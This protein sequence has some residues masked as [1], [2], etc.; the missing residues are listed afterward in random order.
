MSER[1]VLIS[2]D[3]HAGPPV[4][5]YRA[6]LDAE[7][8]ESFDRF[9]D[10]RDRWRRTRFEAAGLPPDGEAVH[11]LFGEK[12]VESYQR[13]E[14]VRRGGVDGVHDSDRRTTELEAEG[15][16][17]E[18]LFPD[19]QNGNEPPWGAAFPFPG[20]NPPLRLAGARAYNRWLADFCGQLPGRRAG[21]A[22]VQPHDI[23]V[24]VDEVRRARAVGLASI[25]LPTGD[26][27]LAS[28]HDSRYDPLWAACVE[29]DLPVTIH[30]GGAPWEGYGPTP[31]GSRRSSS[32]GGA[33]VRSGSSSSVGCSNGSRP[34]DSR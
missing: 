8:V 28:Y 33:A 32:R 12:M 4:A 11:A 7:F 16:V 2:A 27:D 18:V 29:H 30:S 34:F 6:Y 5:E 15:I 13:L 17:A 3:G 20:T 24:A 21:V 25:M 23:D 14:A 9:L 22:I 31:R 1:V 26:H 19:F 10:E